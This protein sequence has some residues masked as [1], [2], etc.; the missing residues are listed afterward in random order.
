MIPYPIAAALLSADHP[1]QQAPDAYMYGSL[2]CHLISHF[3]FVVFP[4]NI[5][6]SLS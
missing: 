3:L 2:L 5:I 1:D 6:I 4:T